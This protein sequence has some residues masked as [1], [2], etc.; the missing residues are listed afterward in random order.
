[1]K[2]QSYAATQVP[3]LYHRSRG[4]D[5]PIGLEEGRLET[6]RPVYDLLEISPLARQLASG[7][8]EHWIATSLQEAEQRKTSHSNG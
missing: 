2:I 7:V 4:D 3:N 5:H 1:M 8:I 6:E